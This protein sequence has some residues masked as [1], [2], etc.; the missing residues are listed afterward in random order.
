MDGDAILCRRGHARDDRAVVCR[1]QAQ[2][3]LWRHGHHCDPPDRHVLRIRNPAQG[4]PASLLSPDCTRSRP[5]FETS[6]TRPTLITRRGV[7]SSSRWEVSDSAKRFYLRASSMT[8]ELP[9]SSA[10]SR[11]DLIL[12]FWRCCSDHVIERVVLGLDIWPI[13]ALFS[14]IVL[15]IATFISHTYVDAAATYPSSG[16]DD[17]SSRS[18]D[19]RCSR[20]PDRGTNRNGELMQQYSL[21]CIAYSQRH[22]FVSAGN[23]CPSPSPLD[24]CDFAHLFGRNGFASQRL[25]KL[26]SVS[27]SCFSRFHRNTSSDVDRTV[28]HAVSPSKTM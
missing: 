7:S 28:R 4:Q 8:C 1:E 14:V 23:G 13:L 9:F 10:G 18:Q 5:D 15:I 16:A 20:R 22:A 11:A 24:L 3:A 26:A 12:I 21:F 17:S 6:K 19:R 25:P 2:L 27:I